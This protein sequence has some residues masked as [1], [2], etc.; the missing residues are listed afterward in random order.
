MVKVGA[1]QKWAGLLGYYCNI[2]ECL[3]QEARRPEP[4]LTTISSNSCVATAVRTRAPENPVLV[5]QP[6][7]KDTIQKTCLYFYCQKYFWVAGSFSSGG[8]QRYWN[9]LPLRLIKAEEVITWWKPLGSCGGFRG[10]SSGIPLTSK[11]N[12]AKEVKFWPI[13]HSGSRTDKF[14]VCSCFG[15]FTPRSFLAD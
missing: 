12:Q 3:P 6:T 9:P 5:P 14:L 15:L 2:W 7:G 10:S 1:F 4:A 11:A 8:P 13:Q